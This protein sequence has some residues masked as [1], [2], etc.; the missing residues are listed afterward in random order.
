[1][2]WTKHFRQ[3]LEERDIRLEWIEQTIQSPDQIE[4]K[5]DGTR[6]FVKRIGEYG[7]RWLRVIVNTRTNPNRAVTAFFDRRLRRP[8][9]EN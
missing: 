8:L 4:D 1:M 5:P 9:H 6:H 3:M 7:E 2:D